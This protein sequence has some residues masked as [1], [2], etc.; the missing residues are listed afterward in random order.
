M[1]YRHLDIKRETMNNN[2]NSLY[3]ALASN[4]VSFGSD[5]HSRPCCAIDTHFWNYGYKLESDIKNFTEWFNNPYMVKVRDDLNNGIWNPICNLCKIRE[6]AGQPSTRQIF[7]DTLTKVESKTG[8]SWRDH[9]SEI[10]DFDK[11][12]LLDITVGNKCNSA[13][14]MCNPSASD[15]WQREQEEINGRPMDWH[16]ENWY[17]HANA[18]KLIDKLPNLTAIQFVGGEPTINKDHIVMLEKLVETGRSKDISLGYVVNLTAI[19]E[20]LTDLWSNFNTKHITVSI[21]GV[22]K[23][24]EYIRYPFT[25]D[26]VLR[27]LERIKKKSLEKGDYSIGLSHTVIPLN[28]LKLD[29]TLSWWEDQVESNPYFLR[30]LPH[31][32][33]VNNPTYFDPIIMPLAMKQECEKTLQRLSDN[34][35]DRN[36]EGKYESVITNIRKNIINTLIDDNHRNA[37]W[38]EMK[39]FCERLDKHRNRHIFNYLPF[40]E[41]YW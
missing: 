2:K 13:C 31:I 14:L 35:K 5:G 8:K 20:E 11:I 36:L 33:C 18:L 23:T 40:M 9:R 10:L 25:W 21:D 29:E 7:N 4:S 3:C 22:D 17:N 16:S 28:I 24:N 32:Q 39:I 1:W 27:G 12:F 38:Q 41:Q 34:M 37:R 19:S 6:D 26:K 15:I 30:S